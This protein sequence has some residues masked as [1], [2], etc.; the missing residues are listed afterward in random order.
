MNARAEFPTR[1]KVRV[2][3]QDW[4][5]HH[6]NRL[7]DTGGVYSKVAALSD[8]LGIAETA[9]ITRWH[10]LRGVCG[11]ELQRPSGKKPEAKKSEGV[12]SRPKRRNNGIKADVTAMRRPRLEAVRDV[13]GTLSPTRGRI[14]KDVA[15]EPGST[16]DRLAEKIGISLGSMS[17]AIRILRS[18]LLEHGW[19]IEAAP[20]GGYYI[21]EI[22]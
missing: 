1:S 11:V 7:R 15:Q 22:A 5:L 16:T 12:T 19:S 6:D 8:E 10:K 18:E 4:D 13:A 3:P 20:R 14:L 9:L 2:L 21:V 17:S